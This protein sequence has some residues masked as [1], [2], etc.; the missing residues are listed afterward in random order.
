MER[1]NIEELR[2]KAMRLPLSPGVYI[3]KSSGGRII[4]VGKS[5]A[6]KNRVSR[7]F[8]D[9]PK[10]S[11]TS[12]MVSS[13]WDFE[14]MV[15]DT[16][17][18][19][20][21]LE[22]KLIK[23]HNPKY[24][25]LL[26][27]GKS[28]PYIKVTLGEEYP[29][30]SLTRRR[31]NDKSRYFGPY[32]SAAKARA[33]VN[34]V[35]AAF[36][37][38]TCKRVFPR[39]IGKERPCIYSDINRCCAVCSGK[40]SSEE[41]RERFAEVVSFL[42]GN[43]KDVRASLESKM[44]EASLALAFE[45]A[46]IYRDRM[47]ALDMLW[48]KQKVIGKPGDEFDIISLYDNSVCACITVYYVRDGAVMDSSNF[49]FSGEKIIDSDALESFICEMYR[50]REDIP[51]TIYLGFELSEDSVFVISEALSEISGYKVSLKIPSKGEHKKMCNMVSDNAKI[52]AE[53]FISESQKDNELLVKLATTLSLEV[54]PQ[55]IEAVDISNYGDESIVA[56]LIALQD[57]KF[58]KKSYRIYKM[59]TVDTRDDYASMI[60]A[61]IRRVGHKEEN[62]LPDLLLLDGGASHVMVIKRT[63]EELGVFLPVFGMVKDDFHKTRTLT[64]GQNEISIAKD[65]AL[66][67]FIFKIQEEVHRFAI[68]ASSRDK[69]KKITRSSLENIEGIGRVKAKLLLDRFKSIKNIRE[70]SIEDIASVRG[71][72]LTDAERIKKYFEE[73]DGRK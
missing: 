71:I 67:T 11:K 56:G 29:R 23:L 48:D 53:D 3:M 4:Y 18:E 43:F 25:I 65:Q 1:K 62:P 17:T 15:T 69:S 13:V 30:V 39:D 37:L 21:A 38:P 41:Y 58:H 31:L 46:A 68:S 61:I 35:N 47:L 49:I 45:A 36:K 26:K 16:E 40:I 9:I 33:V 20:L 70:A 54:V 52:H 73:K 72:S 44:K 64:D 66:F 59:R 19:A 12:A 63:L 8:S 55:T 28:Y 32:S 27:D 5:K 60:E 50:S 2:E 7:Y 14:Y 34:A 51:R 24:N 57:G 6:L 10:D 22:N 42:R